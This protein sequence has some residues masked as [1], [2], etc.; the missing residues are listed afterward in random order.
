MNPQNQNFTEPEIV[1]TAEI[2]HRSY[3][4][5]YFKNERVYIYKHNCLIISTIINSKSYKH[6]FPS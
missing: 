6:Y 4:S 3:V 1:T 2:N 5:F